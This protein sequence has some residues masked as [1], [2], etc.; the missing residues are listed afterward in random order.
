MNRNLWLL[1]V[2]QG[3]FLTN[4][5]TFIAIN[6]L[7]GLALAP[8]FYAFAGVLH[9]LGQKLVRLGVPLERTASAYL[10][11]FAVLIVLGA[12]FQLLGFNFE[13]Q[14]ALGFLLAIPMAVVFFRALGAATGLSAW[15]QFGIACLVAFILC[16][17]CCLAPLMLLGGIG[18]F[19]AWGLTHA[20]PST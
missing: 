4:N 13:L 14:A 6:G 18:A 19:I 3:L 9:F 2:C 7:V 8:L 10:L 11:A 5:V 17:C 1:A 20:Y 15:V 16:C 12:P